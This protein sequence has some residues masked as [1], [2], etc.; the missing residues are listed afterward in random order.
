MLVARYT[1]YIFTNMHCIVRWLC[2]MKHSLHPPLP[3]LTNQMQFISLLTLSVQTAHPSLTLSLSRPQPL[4]PTR[5]HTIALQGVSLWLDE[6]RGRT[7]ASY[8]LPAAASPSACHTSQSQ[9]Q[10]VAGGLSVG[11][12]NRTA[13][14]YCCCV[15][16]THPTVARIHL[17]C[18]AWI[19]KAV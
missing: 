8:W 6:S 3:P 9:H 18:P 10:L 7:A 17:H 11:G 16:S 15:F 1:T 13:C 2:V 19:C 4:S 14:P 5:R 12:V